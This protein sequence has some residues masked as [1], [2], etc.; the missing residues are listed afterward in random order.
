M[1]YAQSNAYETE[2]VQLRNLINGFIFLSQTHELLHIM[3]GENSGDPAVAYDQFRDL[4]EHNRKNPELLSVVLAFDRI[5]DPYSPRNTGAIELDALVD[6]LQMSFQLGYQAIFKAY[7]YFGEVPSS[8]EG[9]QLLKKK[10]EVLED[11]TELKFIF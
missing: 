2:R 7:G 9:L 8:R 5:T 10:I 1:L 6:H 11:W 4:L 3:V